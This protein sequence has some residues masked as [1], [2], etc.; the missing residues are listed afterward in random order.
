MTGQHLRYWKKLD[1]QSNRS[2]GAGYLPVEF[3]LSSFSIYS[4]A[5]R[6]KRELEYSFWFDVPKKAW[7]LV[8]SVHQDYQ[9]AFR[10]LERVAKLALSLKYSYDNYVKQENE[11]KGD[12][13]WDSVIVNGHRI[14][15]DAEGYCS[16]MDYIKRI[17]SSYS[18]LMWDLE[19]Y[20]GIDVEDN[21]LFEEDIILKRALHLLQEEE[22]RNDVS[23]SE[24]PLPRRRRVPRSQDVVEKND[25]EMQLSVRH[26]L[27]LAA[28]EE[29]E[30]NVRTVDRRWP[31]MDLVGMRV[32]NEG[33]LLP[34]VLPGVTWKCPID[35]NWGI[36]VDDRKS[37]LHFEE[38][39][40]HAH[41]AEHARVLVDAWNEN[42]PDQRAI[43]VPPENHPAYEA[44]VRA[45][46]LRDA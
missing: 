25:D 42:H 29:P 35:C 23:E 7:M 1:D 6:E 17:L 43:F 21:D 38:A 20:E 18:F 30:E 40:V 4:P 27:F 45:R 11:A 9:C 33:P 44:L 34:H 8:K 24:A 46:E 12:A 3:P 19:N 39:K 32:V 36:K 2:A 37:N 15:M 26:P 14:S 41:I 28:V 10:N 13:F 5:T 31:H 16:R 22:I